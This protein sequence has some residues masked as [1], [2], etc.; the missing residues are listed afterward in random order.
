MRRPIAKLKHGN[1]RNISF[2]SWD[3]RIESIKLLRGQ[4]RLKRG[5]VEIFIWAV[6]ASQ[7]ESES[8]P[9]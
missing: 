8:L 6:M 9:N 7:I 3:A 1:G 2:R 4:R 5:A